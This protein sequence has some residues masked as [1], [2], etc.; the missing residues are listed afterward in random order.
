MADPAVPDVPALATWPGVEIL[1]TGT[2]KLASGEATFTTADLASAIDAASC[3]AV[4]S[5]ILKI[6]HTD[7]RFA[8]GDGEPAIGHVVNMA[9]S[10]EGNKITGDLAG[11]PGWLGEILPSAYPQRSIEGAYDL[12]CQIGHVHPFAIT[13]LAL[14]GVTPPGV[15][16]LSGLEDVAALYGVTATGQHSARAWALRSGDPMAGIV[17][18]AGVTTEDVRRAYYDSPNV[19]YAM[20]ITELQLDPP[21]LI[22]ADEGTNKVY[23]VPVTIKGEDIEFGD[24]V[25]V[26]IEYMDV[27]AKKS[28]AGRKALRFAS[29]DES[30]EGVVAAWSAASA[31]KGLGDSPTAAKIKQM[32]ALPAGTVSDSKL[33]HHDAADGKVGA[34]NADGCSAAIGAINGAHGGIKGVTAAD[35]KKAYNHL[36][37]HLKDAGQEPPDYS[38]P[39]AAALERVQKLAE[40]VRAQAGADADD[41]VNLLLAGLDATLDAASELTASVDRTSVP[42]D[43]GQ[44]L[45]LITAAESLVDELMD[46]LG[47]T[48][49][50][51]ESTEASA[52]V[53]K[54]EVDAGKTVKHSHAHAAYGAQGD[55]TTHEHEH[56]HP[57][58][59]SRHD[60]HAPAAK[61]RPARENPKGAAEMDFSDDQ[62]AKIRAKLGKPEDH[63]LTADE[64]LAALTAEQPEPV[65]ASA[66][67]PEGVIA[68][69]KDVWE[70]TQ[71]RIAQGE[72]ARE[73]QLRNDRD[74][75]IA[76]AMR[77]GKFPLARK[78]HWE[79]L[80]DADPEGTRTVLAGLTAGV[81]PLDDIGVPGG[82]GDELIEEE[83]RRI[84]PPSYTRTNAE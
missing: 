50:D 51:D 6:G 75:E 64:I 72:A 60:H 12:V 7:K 13:A 52:R 29:A 14:L 63:E 24:P 21:Q 36:A 11:M 53:A 23:R 9:L 77:S 56:E 46:L 34:A 71:R 10:T 54:H 49:P 39:T 45:D 17:L 2:W 35:A 37:A 57:A 66:K 15:G 38:G 48:D 5:P 4:G 32:F 42:A 27:P 76:A 79:R 55:D 20:W 30:R 8:A 26:S 47:I 82:P 31:I 62:L 41:N 22:V 70:A 19:T 84:F 83:Y 59:T 73:R 74:T 25:E 43:V 68:I 78:P 80:W 81:V 58:G 67:L 18:A 69:D 33:P 28:A 65:A 16:V 3:P 1:A 61:R 40:L 44:A